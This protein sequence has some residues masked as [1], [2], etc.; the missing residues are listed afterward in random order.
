MG[1]TGAGKSTFINYL[2]QD[3]RLRCQVGHGLTSCTSE[4]QAITLTF[5]NE[6]F[7]Q[8]YTFTLVDTPGFDDTYVGDVAIL[9]R[10]A[11][12]LQEAYR[13]NKDLGGVIYLHDIYNERFSGTAKRNL[14]MFNRMCGDAAL[15]KVII[16]TTKWGRTSLH[17]GAGHE[18][19]LKK[20]HWL[21]MLEKGAR[22]MRFEDSYDSALS[23]IRQ[24]VRDPSLNPASL[25]IQEEVVE[26]R[27]AASKTEAKR[28]REIV[29]PI[30]GA[31]GA[32]KSTFV[33]YLV[34]DKQQKSKVGHGLSTRCT[35][36]SHRITLTF[37]NDPILQQ[38]TVVL[39]DTPGFDDN[40]K[41]DTAILENIADLFKE[42]VYREKKVL[43][44]V[45]YLH[46]I[47]SD[48]FSGTAR[49][50]LDMFNLLCGNDVLEKVIIGTTKWRRTTAEIEAKHEKE[51]K[52]VHWR[53]ILEKGAKPMVFHDSYDSALSFIR[54][55]LRGG[56]L[57]ICLKIQQEIVDD[58]KIIPE[59]QA[60]RELRYTLK[61]ILEMQKKMVELERALATGGGDSAAQREHEDTRQKMDDLMVQIEKLKVPFFR[62]L[63]RFFGVL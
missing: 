28:R 56:M 35:L 19:E 55:I 6:S 52:E 53:P 57:R 49:R 26:D 54:E 63:K 20:V 25:R 51:L 18:D 33:N 2:V 21:S 36:K 37:P 60:G 46:D 30:M 3:E 7:L 10:I 24:I 38:Y 13:Q 59:T 9:Q 5:P 47:S 42:K 11:D 15:E 1:A 17:E 44:G 40:C 48:S 61:E 8:R 22:T 14:D 27:R 4:L 41:G 43:G 62:K 39:V 29:I 12:W 31:T 23:F 34:Q 32:G 16:G 50:T 58:R 45:I